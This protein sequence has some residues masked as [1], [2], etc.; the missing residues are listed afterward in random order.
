MQRSSLT[1]RSLGL[2]LAAVLTGCG[3]DSTPVISEADHALAEQTAVQTPFMLLSIAINVDELPVAPSSQRAA[4]LG[5]RLAR[6]HSRGTPQVTTH[7]CDNGGTY[8]YSEMTGVD[9][10]EFFDCRFDD[11]LELLTGVRLVSA[12]NGTVRYTYQDDATM[13]IAYLTEENTVTRFYTDQNQETGSET[14]TSSLWFGSNATSYHIRNMRYSVQYKGDQRDYSLYGEGFNAVVNR[15]TGMT[16]SGTVGSQG[17]LGGQAL[18]TTRLQ[19]STS[20]PLLFSSSAQDSN[21]VAG[22][23]RVVANDNSALD[24]TFRSTDYVA[25]IV[26]P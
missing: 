13:N 3:G 23:V 26:K 14:I 16:F 21:L 10:I 9:L 15:K 5:W 18:P 17:T 7:T 2:L 12:L 20:D 1:G 8:T 6:E 4:A 19:A 11:G 25:A 22:K 24:V